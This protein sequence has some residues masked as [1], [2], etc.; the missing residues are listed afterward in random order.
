MYAMAGSAVAKAPIA[1]TTVAANSRA[2]SMVHALIQL[3]LRA[4]EDALQLDLLALAGL[5]STR[6]DERPLIAC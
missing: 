5:Q 3:A 4:I 6:S 1:P 2:M